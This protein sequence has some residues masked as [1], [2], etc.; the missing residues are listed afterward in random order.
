MSYEQSI[1]L[2]DEETVLAECGPMRLAIRAW[3][4]GRLQLKLGQKA[5]EEAFICLERI[6]RLRAMLSQPAVKILNLP[7]DDSARQMIQNVKAIGDTDLTPMAAVAGTIAD[8]VADWLVDR[9]TTKAVV[10]NGG[11]LS[12]RLSADE[13]V[14][15][16]IRPKIS[17]LDISHM[18]NLNSDR[19]S[20]GITTSGLG[21]RSFTRGIA[22][23]VTAVADNASIADAAATAIANACFVKD[24]NIIQMPAE[25]LDPNTDLRGIQVT[26]KVGALSREHKS[27]AVNQ[28]LKKAEHLSKQ[29]II[30]GAFIA[31]EDIFAATKGMEEFI[32]SINQE[33]LD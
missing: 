21:G 9:G 25:L 14:T 11:D 4:D 6:A 29:C 33:H 8:A 16:G 28:A 1:A 7:E 26:V 31:L 22:S 18:I 23:S 13:T 32:T 10:D 15:V 24:N 27:L 19:T 20:W 12:I 17:S 2:L 30:T 5:A 3:K